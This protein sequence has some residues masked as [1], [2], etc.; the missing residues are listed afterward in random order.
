M[1]KPITIPKE[2]PKDSALSY[3]F[4]REEGIQLIQQMAGDTWTDHNTHDPGITILEQLSYGI[5][6]LA[7]RID[8]DIKDLLGR[9]DASSYK[10]LFGPA[11][12]LT[13]NP[14]TLLDL[15]KI[16][17][18]VEGVKNAW[19]EKVSP[20]PFEDLA[21]LENT[22]AIIPKGLYRVIVEKDELSDVGIK[23]LPNV[24]DRLQACR[25]VCE[26]FEEVRL[27]GPQHIRLQGTIEIADK[28]DDINQLVADILYRVSTHL[29]PRISFYTLQELIEQGKRTDEIFE[30][31]ALEHGFID[32]DELRSYT[33]KQEV[34]T[35]DIIREIMDVEDVLAVDK[36]FIAFGTSTVKEW[37]LPLDS[38]KTPKLDISATL[39]TIEFT[40]QG[41]KASIDPE[42]VEKLY[43]KKNIESSG[44]GATRP[45]E[46]DILLAETKDRELSH[47][48]SIQN[49]F[50]SNYGIGKTGLPDSA[51]EKRKAQAKQFTAYLT[52]FEQILANYFSQLAHFKD[53][54]SF[55]GEDCSTYF[56]QSLLDS[57]SGLEDVLVNTECYLK[58]L[59][60]LEKSEADCPTG[61]V[62]D[63]VA[64]FKR[65]NKFLDH[66][67]ARFGEKFTGYGMLLNSA[68]NSDHE[69]AKKLIT[70]KSNFL[71]DYPL[72]SR[73]RAK[74]YDYKKEYWQN[75]NISG[76]EKRIA[77][78]LGIEDY[79]R[80]NLADGNTEGFHMVEHILLRPHTKEPY[81]FKAH[82][83][84]GTITA[85]ED[86]QNPDG[87]YTRCLSEGHTLQEDEQIRIQGPGYYEGTHTIHTVAEDHFEIEIA[88]Q[89]TTDQAIWQRIR[90]DL[91]YLIL[92]E[93]LIGFSAATEAGQTFCETT[94]H[95]LKEG[96]P[97][98]IAGTQ[99]YN[100]TYTIS[101]IAENGFEINIPFVEQETT[102]RWMTGDGSAD[103][104]SL[105]VTFV[106]PKWMERYQNES[107]KKFVENTIR[108]ETPAH[109]RVYIKWLDQS[110][111]QHF[112]QAFYRFLSQMNKR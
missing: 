98:E 32:D 4:L 105:Q 65:K 42:L 37:L 23:L 73:D 49:Q 27:L 29:S 34:H 76:L 86:A 72:L 50:P 21:D 85:F 11:T 48:Y 19:V 84:P 106:I 90:A 107:L 102:G 7:Y 38:T 53:L 24:K 91:R 1:I 111:M 100:G 71:S 2:L 112:D 20:T 12:I 30:G 83:L 110:E 101:A 77:R 44:S 79:S 64:E 109:L 52:L 57:I 97:I 74:A 104:Y 3:D 6:D 93:P 108:E 8:Y 99:H 63:P 95:S 70:D 87:T 41:L 89:N 36:L 46:R 39:N 5:T 96:D 88:F 56:N 81:P 78:K 75:N 45:E 61:S 18:D 69:I 15:R 54:V 94:T 9:D 14:V 58:Y 67:L 31:P 26:D 13:V 60:K 28:V 82:Y 33:R 51:P 16:V 80:R 66:L 43:E 103:H 40:A 59:G 62:A 92:T 22:D 47:Y 35:S 68:S 55:D 17:I 25:A 10:D